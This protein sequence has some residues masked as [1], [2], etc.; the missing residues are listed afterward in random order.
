MIADSRLHTLREIALTLRQDVITMLLTAGSGH[1]AGPLGMADVFATLYFHV[2]NV[3]PENPQHPERDRIVLSNA[4]IAPILYAAL[5]R[6]GFFPVSELT[7]LRKL[8]TRLQGHST[9]THGLPGI[10]TSGGPLGQGTSQAVGMAVALRM[11]QSH[12]R[13]Y[14]MTGDGELNEG[15]CWEAFMLAYKLRLSNLTFCIDRNHIQIDGPTEVVMPLEPLADKLRAFGLAVCECNG[16][17]IPEIISTFERAKENAD[18]PTAIIFH[19]IPGKGVSFMESDFH[20][21][22]IPPNAEQA[23]RALSELRTLQNQITSE[24]A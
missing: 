10:E 6:R 15:Q 18:R 22:G 19:T 1:S 17:D 11:K 3:Y 23:Q 14:C 5:A 9:P 8:D 21:H 16:H 13:V 12:S 2:A 4:H 24:H 7:T 20:W